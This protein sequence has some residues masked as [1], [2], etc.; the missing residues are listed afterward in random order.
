[1]ASLPMTMASVASWEVDRVEKGK[2][3]WNPN[4]DDELGKMGDGRA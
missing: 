4:V 1:M 3:Q 2:G